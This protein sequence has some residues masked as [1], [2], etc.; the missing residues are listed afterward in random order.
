[1][2]PGQLLDG[3]QFHR[4]RAFEVLKNSRNSRHDA[5]AA[6]GQA[7]FAAALPHAGRSNPIIIAHSTKFHSTELCFDRAV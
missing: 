5:H 6:L 2:L 3:H 4:S 1:M 7:W